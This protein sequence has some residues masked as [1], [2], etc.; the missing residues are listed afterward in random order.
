MNSKEGDKNLCS[1]PKT[2]RVVWCRGN[3]HRTVDAHWNKVI[4]SN[5]CKVI[6]GQD[7]RVRVWSSDGN[8]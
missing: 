7:T 2:N 3:L 4:F 1:E 8:R 5:E 6:I